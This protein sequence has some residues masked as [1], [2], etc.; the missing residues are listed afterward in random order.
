MSSCCRILLVG[1]ALF[2]LSSS[3]FAQPADESLAARI[4][5]LTML[6]HSNRLLAARPL[7]AEVRDEVPPEMVANL[8]FYQALSYVFEYYEKGYAKAL[9]TAIEQ[10]SAFI[11]NH[12]HHDL[13]ALARYNLADAHAISQDFEQALKL[14]VPLYRHPMAS[15]DRKEVLKKLVL[16]YAAKQ[17]WAAGTPYFKDNMRLAESS[18]DRTT[19]AAYLLIAQA[20]SGEVVDSSQLLEFFKSPAPVFYTPRFNAALMEVGDNLKKEGDLATASLFYQFVRD[21]EALEAGLTAYIQSLELRVAKF[22]DNPVL[23]NFYVEAKASLENARADLEALRTSTNYTPLLNWRIAGVYM[24]MGR[25]WEAFWRFRLMVDTYPDHKFAEDILFSAYSLGHQLGEYQIAEELGRRYLDDG[26]NTR[27]RGTVADQISGIYQ[28]NSNHDEL[29]KLTTWYLERAPDDSAAQLLLFK[30]AVTRMTLLENQLLIQDFLEYKEKYDTNKCAVVLHYFLGLAYLLEQENEPAVPMFDKVIVDSNQ[31]FRA[32]ASF[33]KAQAVLGLDRIEEA[34]D[35]LVQFISEYPNN[36]LRAE[37]E[38]TLGNVVDMLGA[39]E[40]ALTHYYLVEAHTTDRAL[41]AQAELKISRILVDRRQTDEAIKRLET[42]LA[43]HGDYAESIPVS[44]ALSKI[45]IDS[46]QPRVALGVLKQP[47]DNFFK[48]T[49]IHQLD[50]LLIDYLRLDRKLKTSQVATNEF[51]ALVKTD[52]ALLEELINDRAKQYRYF[53]TN[54]SIDALIQDSFVRDNAFRKAVLEDPSALDALQNKV[55]TLNA[56]IPAE[57]ADDLLE[58]A[59]TEAHAGSNMPLVVRIKTALAKAAT[60]ELVPDLDLLKLLDDPKQWAQLGSSGQLWILGEHAKNAPD[61]V[62]AVLEASRLDFINTPSE[63]GLHQLQAQCYQQLGRV[64]ESI[65]AY[66][67]LIKRFAQAKEAGKASMQIGEMEVA[68]KNAAAARL[69]LEGILHRNEW[70]GKMHAEALLWIGRSYV[71][72]E[73]Y[74]EAHGFF[75]RII[76]GYPG[77]SEVLAMAFYEDI[78]VLKLMGETTSVQMVYDA[79]KLTPSL[80]GTEGAELIGKEFE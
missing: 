33:R 40:E 44:A 9:N 54:D 22:A 28:A 29:F 70:R 67:T 72:E 24:E 74:A 26:R 60:P 76:L 63:L 48:Q 31:R 21:Y 42:F 61:R 55:D 46:N 25:Y 68:R 11:K 58:N 7:M 59:L 62:V 45:L 30:H 50:D 32:D 52:P 57:T 49:E 37:A 8:D 19:S 77:F 35:L 53:K 20:K 38:L 27:Y 14:Y 15:V 39:T 18:E 17:E 16:I 51:L 34:R 6:L 36:N 78:Q 73:K 23:R 4:E 69:E 80:E 79:F 41:L 64:E 1:A 65:E 10:F 5:R 56:S 66:R 13:N 75:E 43:R 12:P 3:T 2:V 71:V 47:L